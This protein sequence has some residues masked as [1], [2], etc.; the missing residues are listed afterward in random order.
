MFKVK[1]HSLNYFGKS[2]ISVVI[3]N[4]E[5]R[6]VPDR[7]RV[8]ARCAVTTPLL[9]SRHPLN[10]YPQRNGVRFLDAVDL[11]IICRFI[12]AHL[13]FIGFRIHGVTKGT[14]NVA[15]SVC[16]FFTNLYL[17]NWKRQTAEIYVTYFTEK[18]ILILFYEVKVFALVFCDKQYICLD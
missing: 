18:F 5:R 1:P 13:Y 7:W 14:V 9:F 3:S 4:S 16:L 2:I 12:L 17:E 10:Y 15:M 8:A 11:I 6:L